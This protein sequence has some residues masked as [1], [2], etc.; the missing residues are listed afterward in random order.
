MARLK[1]FFSNESTLAALLVGLVTLI[2]YAPLIPQ[3][4]YYQDD[5]YLLW[6]GQARGAASIISL[7]ST[8]RPFM[9]YLYA[10]D[11]S[12]L[13]DTLLNWHLYAL[14]LRLA[15]IYALLWLLRTLWP[16]KKF[17]VTLT[18]LLFIVYPG[19]LNQPIANTFQNHLFTYSTAILSMAFA[20]KAVLAEKKTIRWMLW[21]L[22]L[23]FTALYLPVYE[24]MIGLEGLKF[25]FLGLALGQ[26]ET[27]PL[28]QNIL[29]TVKHYLPY[30]L[31]SAAFVYWRF[32]IFESSRAATREGDLL[33]SLGSSLRSLLSLVV[34][35]SKDVLDTALYAWAIPPYRLFSEASY[36]RLA[37][38]LAWAGLAV[39]LAWGYYTSLKRKEGPVEDD[40]KFSYLLIGAGL[41]GVFITLFPV[42]FAGRSVIFNGFERYTLQASLGVGL[43]FVGLLLSIQPK[44]RIWL[45][46]FLLGLGVSTHILNAYAWSD[47]WSIHRELWWQITWRAPELQDNT[48]VVAYLPEGYRLQQDYEA[49]GP[50]NL[51]YRPGTAKAPAI[52]SEV[53]NLDTAYDALRQVKRLNHVRDVEV[54]QDFQNMLLITIPSTLSCAHVIDGALPVYSEF[55]SLLAQ[56]VG[57]Y[58]Q[59][60]RIIPSGAAPTPPQRIFGE[61]PER[62][63]CYYYQKASLAR[64]VGDWEEVVRLYHQALEQGLEPLDKSELVPFFEALVNTG[65]YDEAQAMYDQDIKG[66]R[67]LRLPLCAF[68]AQDPGYPPEF[69]YDYETIH[70]IL[71]DS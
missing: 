49:W 55:E 4:G 54:L 37:L 27:Q 20:V 22:S 16:E 70:K 42:V 29:R 39:L 3:L 7:F 25:V 36:T 28:K 34:E 1:K 68:L 14:F 26:K 17:A 65:R 10:L 6:S 66:R 58:S 71:C 5:W 38:A 60:D 50:L 30:G 9:G 40:P 61:E 13:G 52:Q 62:G 21:L 2:T 11:Y 43:L 12:L 8:D 18:V 53:L 47:L 44:V 63:W 59:V 56:Q 35:T 15:G 51:I 46:L 32:F 64:Q 23:L 48:Q 33:S 41:F 31:I 69:G 24:Y 19:F 45:A 57:T 67:E